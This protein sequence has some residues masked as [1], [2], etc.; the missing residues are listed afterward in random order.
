VAPT[1]D[2]QWAPWDSSPATAGS[3]DG[4]D[5]PDEGLNFVTITPMPKVWGWGDFIWLKTGE[6]LSLFQNGK[7]HFSVRT[8]YP[9]KLEF[10]F[11]TNN[12]KG[13]ALL[14]VDPA[15]NAYGY[16]NDGTWAHVAIP[17]T[18]L[19][20]T[21]TTVDLTNVDSALTIDDRFGNTGKASGFTATTTI[22]I[23][24]VYWTQN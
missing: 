21:S 24:N 20:G 10:G 16:K 6:D 1:G 15:N 17:V 7:V 13:D 18:A 23:D 9:G 5:T 12:T 3:A 11:H 8:L 2:W 4:T 22:D 19:I 14:V